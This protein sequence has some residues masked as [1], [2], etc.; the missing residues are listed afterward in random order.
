MKP[1]R[2]VWST[3]RLLAVALAA[4]SGLAGA[5]LLVSCSSSSSS[6]STSVGPGGGSVLAA[7]GTGVSVPAG[8]LT[9]ST[10]IT[11]LGDP[12]AITLSDDVPVGPS[13][14]FGPEGTTFALPVN[15]TLAYDPG[16]LPMGGTASDVE[17]MTAPLGSSAFVALTTSIV[18]ATHVSAT[19]THFSRFVAT[20]KKMPHADH[21]VP[22]DQSVSPADAS[23]PDQG[24]SSADQSMPVDM[25][26]LCPHT[27]SGFQQCTLTASGTNC[28]GTFSLNC[29]M[30]MCSCQGNNL[31]KL[32]PKPSPQPNSFGC[33]SQA[34][35]ETVWTSCCGFP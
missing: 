3:T 34:D 14:R 6:A 19:T 20:A 32:C 13:Y 4:A 11:I 18:D 5:A 35:M 8:A 2:T 24:T 17:I 25:T 21:G 27:F 10:V 30:A 26:S 33:P 12:D 16:K 15:V 28:G 1:D 31:N 23:P 22:V 9:Q 7:D 29:Q